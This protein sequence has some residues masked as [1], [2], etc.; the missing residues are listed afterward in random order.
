MRKF[1]STLHNT[2]IVSIDDPDLSDMD[3]IAC[4][5]LDVTR[6]FKFDDGVIEEFLTYED[7]IIEGEIQQTILWKRS[8]IVLHTRGKT[9]DDFTNT[10]K[11]TQNFYD[12]YKIFPLKEFNINPILSERLQEQVQHL[13]DYIQKELA[14]FPAHLTLLLSTGPVPPHTDV[15]HDQVSKFHNKGLEPSQIKIMLNLE[16]YDDSLFFLKYGTWGQSLIPEIKYFEKEKHMPAETNCFAW[17]E[18][19]HRHG[20]VFEDNKTY[21]AIISIQGPLDKEKHKLII[22][23][24]FKKYK[25]NVV[26]F[27]MGNNPTYVWENT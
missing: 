26:A 21:R 24:S 12:R 5:P 16:D 22:D 17:S 11:L 15:P 23:N 7:R 2:P 4:M 13:I 8:E 27:E 18:N 1:P 14:I 19:F 20:A 10:T 25:H 3:Q 6:P 9:P